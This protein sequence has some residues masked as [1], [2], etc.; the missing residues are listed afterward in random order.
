MQSLTRAAAARGR[1]ASTPGWMATAARTALNLHSDMAKSIN[2]FGLRRGST[3]SHTYQVLRGEQ[4]TKDRV[5]SVSNPQSTLQMEQRLKLPMVSAMRAVFKELVNHSFEGITYGDPSLKYFSSQNL[6]KDGGLVPVL[7]VPK[8]IG[9]TGAANFL[10]SKGTLQVQTF[11]DDIDNISALTTQT[12]YHTMGKTSLSGEIAEN[13]NGALGEQGDT[14]WNSLFSLFGLGE[15]E[16]L[17]FILSYQGSE[18]SWQPSADEEYEGHYHRYVIS[19]LINDK[20]KVS[21]WTITAPTSSDVY[22]NLSDGYLNIRIPQAEGNAATLS[23]NN[24]EGDAI[25]PK[26]LNGRCCIYSKQ[27]N[28]VWQRSTQRMEMWDTTSA[29]ATYDYDMVVPTYLKTKAAS[30]KY[31]NTGTEGVGITGSN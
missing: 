22:W 6:S 5:T 29:K 15:G 10:M 16:Q 20:T 24:K 26:Y 9:D 1:Y 21:Q 18:F 14:L 2:F 17:T 7:Y 13:S 28:N 31:L 4:V 3:K 23:L 12:I 30:S 19:R 25:V 27:T 8:G 11:D